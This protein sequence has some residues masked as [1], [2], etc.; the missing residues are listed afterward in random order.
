MAAFFPDF[1]WVVRDFTLQLQEDGRK[2]TPREYFE[3]ALKHQPPMT[4]EIAHKNRIRTLLSTFF[5]SRDCV[6]MVRP[7]NDENLLRRLI[8]QPYESLRPEFQ[9][10]MAVLKAKVFS[11]LKPKK[12]MAR[13]LNGAMLVSLAQNYV[14]AFNSGSS[15]VIATVWDRVIETQCDDALERAKESFRRRFGRAAP[16]EEAALLQSYEASRADAEKELE[17]EDLS[18]SA[19]MAPYREQL[20][21]FMLEALQDAFVRAKQESEAYNRALLEALFT[22]R[23]AAL[24]SIPSAA[25]SD[26]AQALQDALSESCTLMEETVAKYRE[27]AR[28]SRKAAVLSDFLA[29]KLMAGLLDWGSTVKTAFRAA[30]A[31]LDSRVAVLRQSLRS[32]EGKIRAGEELLAQQQ[33]SYEHALQ[34]LAMRTAEE[35]HELQ[36]EIQSVSAE[37]ARTQLQIA[38]LAS[39]HADALAQLDAQVEEAKEERRRLEARVRDAH[40]RRESER[41]EATRLLLES[42]RH[43][44]REEKGL[45]HSQQQL[46]QRIITLERQLGEQDTAQMEEVFRLEQA[47]ELQAT[48]LHLQYQ[49][50]REELKDRAAQV[51]NSRQSGGNSARRR[52]RILTSSGTGDPRAQGRAGRA[53]GRARRRP[54]R[55]KGAAG[56]AARTAGG[57]AGD[58]RA[59]EGARVPRRRL[60]APVTRRS[61]F[62]AFHLKCALHLLHE[63]QPATSVDGR[64]LRRAAALR[65][66]D[67]RSEAAGGWRSRRVW[68]SA[69]S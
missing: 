49:D 30:E 7:L 12:V 11:S 31:Q 55:P 57:E 13:L 24:G 67:V 40:A 46:L 64:R 47:A 10:Q 56:G 5:P 19:A 52:L 18:A 14:D 38:R 1:L 34:A 33:E 60:R 44:H 54:E 59:E 41:L 58:R 2:V 68:Q 9:E 22:P 15:P 23:T 50:E 61:T 8:H 51:R 65:A 28:G 66:R 69:C 21:A 62:V 48:E 39:L 16:L 25:A 27:Q 36:D 32:I 26:G 29:E 4:E 63:R 45:L 42:E 37:I 53:A 43:F 3:S 17:L 6:T 20:S 35:Q